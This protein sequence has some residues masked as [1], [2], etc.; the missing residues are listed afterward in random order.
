MLCSPGTR[1]VTQHPVAALRTPTLRVRLS[2]NTQCHQREREK[3]VCLKATDPGGYEQNDQR[4]LLGE[5]LPRPRLILFG[6][7]KPGS[8]L[9]SLHRPTKGPQ[10]ERLKT[11]RT[12]YRTLLEVRGQACSRSKGESLPGCDSGSN[13]EECAFALPSF[14]A[15][16][17][18][19]AGL[20]PAPPS[21]R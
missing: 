9:V 5:R 13:H 11:A 19:E 17:S 1:I 20:A 4:V 18:P 7:E 14:R 21:D 6:E 15:L 3:Q 12:Y 16:S 2:Q 10:P 8:T